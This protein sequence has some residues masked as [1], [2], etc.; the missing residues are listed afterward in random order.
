MR[1]VVALL[2][3]IS[4]LACSKK[5]AVDSVRPDPEA[6]TGAE[7]REDLIDFSRQAGGQDSPSRP[8][9]V[10]EEPAP[11]PAQGPPRKTMPKKLPGKRMEPD[12]ELPPPSPAVSQEPATDRPFTP[13]EIS[14]FILDR[15]V[16]AQAFLVKRD[17]TCLRF[18]KEGQTYSKDG[19]FH[20]LRAEWDLQSENPEAALVQAEQALRRPFSLN[21]EGPKNASLLICRALDAIKAARPSEEVQQR[22]SAAWLKFN[23]TYSP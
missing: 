14:R 23:L 4:L 13:E 9:P 5:D 6:R 16:Q 10:I 19:S 2:M 21:P 20:L 18:I 7:L 3:A 17:P 1:A 22:A 15:Y 12:F 8:A 11:Q